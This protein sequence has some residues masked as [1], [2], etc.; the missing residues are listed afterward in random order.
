VEWILWWN[1]TL[2][3]LF[4]F[5]EQEYKGSQSTICVLQNIEID[6]ELPGAMRASQESYVLSI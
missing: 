4:T 6:Q 1:Q 2:V 3:R 5:G